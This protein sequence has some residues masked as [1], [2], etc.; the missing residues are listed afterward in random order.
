MEQRTQPPTET[1]A[2]RRTGTER[3]KTTHILSFTLISVYQ[4]TH[5]EA[6]GSTPSGDI[7]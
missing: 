6:E 5:R 3:H 7:L 1:G 2:G 4:G